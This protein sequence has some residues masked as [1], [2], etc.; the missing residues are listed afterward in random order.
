MIN[1]S[2]LSLKVTH[3]STQLQT[4]PEDTCDNTDTEMEEASDIEEEGMTKKQEKTWTEMQL[5]RE[6]VV[7]EKWVKRWKKKSATAREKEANERARKWYEM[8]KDEGSKENW[9]ASFDMGAEMAMLHQRTHFFEEDEE[10]EDRVELVDVLL[11]R[12]DKGLMRS[13]VK[14][15]KRVGFHYELVVEK[16]T[17][18]LR[19][20]ED[21]VV[22]E[23]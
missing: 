6:V 1:P 15:V 4:P 3:F 12:R 9:E 19:E 10:R 14:G 7:G 23:C 11:Y 20:L 8:V 2:P 21:N 13:E 22:S 16:D 5:K 18:R 17:V